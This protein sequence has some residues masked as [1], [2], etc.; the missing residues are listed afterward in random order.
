MWYLNLKTS[1]FWFAHSKNAFIVA[2]HTYIS[3]CHSK[4]KEKQSNPWFQINDKIGDGNYVG[5]GLN[6]TSLWSFGQMLQCELFSI[7][8]V[9]EQ[10][11]A[12]LM[13]NHDTT[14]SS[15]SLIKSKH[16]RPSGV[17]FH[18][19]TINLITLVWKFNLIKL[20]L[21]L[22]HN[23][24]CSLHRCHHPCVSSWQLQFEII[25]KNCQKLQ[26]VIEVKISGWFA[27]RRSDVH[28]HGKSIL[29]TD[30]DGVDYDD[31]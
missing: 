22:D 24:T 1:W 26:S 2:H 15:S 13:I 29:K 14:S 8:L 11:A 7:R 18:P 31:D 4:Q 27:T 28:S 10:S 19:T 21:D 12:M 9:T 20:C 17:I 5:K 3:P 25:K 30:D 16:R 23:D 6:P